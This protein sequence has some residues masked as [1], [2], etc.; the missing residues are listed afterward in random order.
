[1]TATKRKTAKSQQS[2][3]AAKP[4]GGFSS[5]VFLLT[6]H[7]SIHLASPQSATHQQTTQIQSTHPMFASICIY[8]VIMTVKQP[9][10]HLA[11]FPSSSSVHTSLPLGCLF[12]C[13]FVCSAH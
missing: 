6:V 5:V 3:P 9:F 1:M 13:L 12:V 4:G 11:L 10:I 8:C 7:P 2:E